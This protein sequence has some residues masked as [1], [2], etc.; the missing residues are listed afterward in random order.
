LSVTVAT[1]GTTAVFIFCSGGAEM[2]NSLKG[3]LLSGL[4]LPG[5][6]QVLF[7]HYMRGIVLMFTLCASMSA[8]AALVLAKALP[9]LKKIESD[10]GEI[11]IPMIATVATQAATTSGSLL[12]NALMLLV[13]VCW[14]LAVVDAYRIGRKMDLSGN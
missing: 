4:V 1:A 2:K 13:L 5:L 9:I 11:D 6:G 8:I 3:A 10:G 7:R 12:F 14:I